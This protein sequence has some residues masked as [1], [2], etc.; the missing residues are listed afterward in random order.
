MV[1][2]YYSSFFLIF[3]FFFNDTATTEI[4][5]LSLHDAL[6]ASPPLPSAGS[7]TGVRTPLPPGK[8]PRGGG[9]GPPDRASS[10]SNQILDA[11]YQ[12]L[13][14]LGEGGVSYVYLAK[15]ISSEATV[16]IKVLSPRR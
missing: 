9:G 10:L 3:F 4:Y 1:L 12:V 16:A 8:H 15:E 5:P 11:R 7:G 14:K 6:P 2:F 13:Q